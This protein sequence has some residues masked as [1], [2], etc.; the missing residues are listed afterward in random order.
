[1]QIP[2]NNGGKKSPYCIFVNGG[3]CT[4]NGKGGLTVSALKLEGAV[5]EVVQ[6]LALFA[7]TTMVTHAFHMH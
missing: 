7:G 4:D 2:V 3:L 1:M 6:W 5:L